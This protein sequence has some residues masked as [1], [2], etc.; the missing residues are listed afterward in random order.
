MDVIVK[1]SQ[2]QQSCAFQGFSSA[3]KGL[4]D[5]NAQKRAELG[6]WYVDSLCLD[7]LIWILT[8]MHRQ[9]PNLAV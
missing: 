9:A 8:Y 7:I 6:N 1:T 2:Y 3:G 4:S 5:T